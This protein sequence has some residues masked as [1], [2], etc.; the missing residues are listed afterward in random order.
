MTIVG[1]VAAL[2]VVLSII[3]SNQAG[4]ERAKQEAIRELDKKTSRKLPPS[5][6]E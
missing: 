5:K 6:P 2:F 1:C 3:S 4:R